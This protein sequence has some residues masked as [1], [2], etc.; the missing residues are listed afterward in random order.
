MVNQKFKNSRETMYLLPFREVRHRV[1]E[2][3]FAVQSVKFLNKKLSR[4]R[5][6][7]IFEAHEETAIREDFIH[8]CKKIIMPEPAVIFITSLL[9]EY[10]L[11]GI[12]VTEE[13]GGFTYKIYLLSPLP[14]TDIPIISVEWNPFGN[15]QYYVKDYKVQKWKYPYE[16]RQMVHDIFFPPAGHSRGDLDVERLFEETHALLQQMCY[17]LNV[18]KVS[19]RGNSR[20]SLDFN[21]GATDPVTIEDLWPYIDA[22]VDIFDIPEENFFDWL[23]DFSIRGFSHFAFGLDS[24]NKPFVTIYDSRGIKEPHPYI[25]NQGIDGPEIQCEYGR[26]TDRR[27]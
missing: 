4:N 18:L 3:L 7:S 1:G 20:L 6:Y 10:R 26:Q 19:E 22:I 9:D 25:Y 5:Y 16:L 27:P 2:N 21:V 11:W 14:K 23:G 24:S 8:F 17:L 13:R 15:D 12:G